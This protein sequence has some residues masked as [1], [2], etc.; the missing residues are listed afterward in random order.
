MKL[1]AFRS[2]EIAASTQAVWDIISDIEH[3]AD[4]ISGIKNIK[5]LEPA[6]GEGMIGLKWQESR[7]WMSRDAVEVMWVT[8][9]LEASFYET[10]AERR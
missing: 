5:V 2:I 4:H 7:E 6:T 8:D 9:A 3:A 10:R 1:I